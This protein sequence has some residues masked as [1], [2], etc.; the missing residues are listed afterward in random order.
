ME[1]FE[2]DKKTFDQIVD[3]VD[4]L[5][6]FISLFDRFYSQAR[7]SDDTR[8]R[9]HD[10]CGITGIYSEQGFGASVDLR[11]LKRRVSKGRAALG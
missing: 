11:K 4:F 9:I 7:Y 3:Y 10:E 1:V 8:R 2:F 6:V 5:D